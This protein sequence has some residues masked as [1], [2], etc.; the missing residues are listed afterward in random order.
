MKGVEK[1]QIAAKSP[2]RNKRPFQARTGHRLSIL[3]LCRATGPTR[4][5][6][7]AYPMHA[8]ASHSHCGTVPC[9]CDTA[10]ACTAHAAASGEHAMV[11]RSVGWDHMAMA[12]TLPMLQL[13][14]SH[15]GF[16]SSNAP[17]RQPAEEPRDGGCHVLWT[18][19]PRD[20]GEHMAIGE[21]REIT[22]PLWAVALPLPHPL[23][24]VAPPPTQPWRDTPLSPTQ[25]PWVGLGNASPGARDT[26]PRKI[27]AVVLSA[28]SLPEL[29]FSL[30]YIPTRDTNR[31]SKSH[32]PPVG[33]CNIAAANP[34]NV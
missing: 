22:L 9:Y 20:G 33:H 29:Q 16:V 34:V 25:P 6:L 17:Q 23:G 5:F 27:N 8:L 14:E 15:L 3:Q 18:R 30:D 7:Y 28:T 32:C 12:P 21:K 19:V 31:E 1:T 26:I 2:R 11:P 10:I 13:K 24:G 4:P